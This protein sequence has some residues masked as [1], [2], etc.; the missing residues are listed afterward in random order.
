VYSEALGMTPLFTAN[1][2]TV[3]ACSKTLPHTKKLMIVFVID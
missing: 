3:S 1:G 2:S